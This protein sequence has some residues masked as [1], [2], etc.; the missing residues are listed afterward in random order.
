MARTVSV[1]TDPKQSQGRAAN[2]AIPGGKPEASTPDDRVRKVGKASTT[3]AGPDGPDARE[4][5][6]TFKRK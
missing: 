4:V 6:E 3:K 1:M 2:G 5:G